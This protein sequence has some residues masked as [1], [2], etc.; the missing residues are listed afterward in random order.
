MKIPKGEV[1]EELAFEGKVGDGAI[2]FFSEL[3]ANY[4]DEY[5]DETTL[6]R[7]IEEDKPEIFIDKRV[8]RCCACGYY[9]RD[10][11]VNNSKV[12]CSDE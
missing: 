11:S 1:I 10:K 8:R 4:V 7:D 2:A 12:A 9:F 3:I 5:I 6:L